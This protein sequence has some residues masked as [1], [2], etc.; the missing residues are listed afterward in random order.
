MGSPSTA[1]STRRPAYRSRGRIVRPP[2]KQTI[3]AA[4]RNS[5]FADRKLPA[6]PDKVAGIAVGGF[7]EIVLMLLLRLPEIARRRKLGD[8]LAWPQSRGI[9]I[10]DGVFGDALLLVAGVEDRR[11]IAH[12]DIVALAVPGGRIV[13]LEKGFE[14]CAKADPGRIEN[15]LDGFGMAAVV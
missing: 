8:D 11:A 6:R 15:D 3:A 5:L 12:S 14:Q 4:L 7:L 2:D 10:G 9:D 13:D 1:T